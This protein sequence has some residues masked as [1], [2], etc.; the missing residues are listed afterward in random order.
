[1]QT[2]Q[3]SPPLAVS[4]SSLADCM[5]PLLSLSYDYYW[6][7][8]Q[9]SIFS[10]TLSTS[11]HWSPKPGYISSSL[12]PSIPLSVSSFWLSPCLYCL[13]LLQLCF[14]LPSVFCLL[15]LLLSFFP[16]SVLFCLFFPFPSLFF[17]LSTLPLLPLSLPPLSLACISSSSLSAPLALVDQTVEAAKL[18][19][20]RADRGAALSNLPP[21]P[22]RQT[23][24]DM[25]ISCKKTIIH[26]LYQLSVF[27]S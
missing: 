15:S 18:P 27:L 21:S 11:C 26:H 8:L 1:M 16:L 7:L 10:F 2:S 13:S 3:T 4:L 19:E 24:A 12:C 22:E 6:L 20:A 9:C 5:C 14:F 17:C 23:N 25:P